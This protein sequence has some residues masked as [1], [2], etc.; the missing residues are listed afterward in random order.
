MAPLH[1]F[2]PLFRAVPA[3]AVA[4]PYLRGRNSLA[5][6]LMPTMVLQSL[7]AVKPVAPC[8]RFKH[9]DGLFFL[10]VVALSF[11]LRVNLAYFWNPQLVLQPGLSG[12][13][14]GISTLRG[15]AG[16][17]CWETRMGLLANGGSRAL[18]AIDTCRYTPTED[19]TSPDKSHMIEKWV[20]FGLDGDEG[21]SVKGGTDGIHIT[22]TA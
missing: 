7:R 9:E 10:G 6:A 4:G 18:M 13:K 19:V 5:R 21:P 11:L 2:P 16:F 12:Q 1:I 3:T 14:A 15:I 20:Y 22:S 8:R 17:T